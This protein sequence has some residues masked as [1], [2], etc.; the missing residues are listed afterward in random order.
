MGTHV[1]IRGGLSTG[2]NSHASPGSLQASDRTERFLRTPRPG[3]RNA[4][5]YSG[6]GSVGDE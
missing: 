6:A 3:E 4:W 1:S 5:G 2:F